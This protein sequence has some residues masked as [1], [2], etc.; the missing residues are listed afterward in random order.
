MKFD[1]QHYI[2]IYRLSLI[3]IAF[4]LIGVVITPWI[5][6]FAS[7]GVKTLIEGV[8]LATIA[9]VTLSLLVVT[10]PVNLIFSKVAHWSSGRL[11]G[12]DKTDVNLRQIFAR[13][14]MW[15]NGVIFLVGGVLLILIVSQFLYLGG[16]R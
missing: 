10:S 4:V 5:L 2:W 8:P 9:G 11:A 16:G 14:I 1:K 13:R 12:R 3:G 7:D 15:I 6:V